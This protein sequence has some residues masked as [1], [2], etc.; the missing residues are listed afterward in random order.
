MKLL[1]T[2]VIPAL[3]AICVVGGLYYYMRMRNDD[4]T[5]CEREIDCVRRVCIEDV[6]GTHCSRSCEDDSECNE[7]WRC[8]RSAG[9][10]YRHRVCVRPL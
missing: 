6:E 1:Y 2:V 3:L 7:G 4:G 5:P 9:L 10:Q 8:I